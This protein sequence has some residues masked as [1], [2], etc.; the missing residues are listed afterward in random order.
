MREREKCRTRWTAVSQ[1]NWHT[2][3][4]SVG[5]VKAAMLHEENIILF[6]TFYFVDGDSK[7]SDADAAGS[8]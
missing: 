3:E 8:S 7:H 4:P 1:W 5:K 2:P 6:G